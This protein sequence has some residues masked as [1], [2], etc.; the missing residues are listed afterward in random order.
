MIAIPLHLDN[1]GVW[2]NGWRFIGV[3][4]T[5]LPNLQNL[6]DSYKG[7]GYGGE[8][9]YPV[10]SHYANW[11]LTINFHNITRQSAELMMQESM[12]VEFLPAFEYQDP[13]SHRT[14]VE[15]WRFATIIQPKGVDLSTLEVGVKQ[16]M[17][18]LCGCTY[19]KASFK[20]ETVFEKDKVNIIDE[21]L[22]TDY[23]KPVRQA[24]GIL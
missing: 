6:T 10:R 16:N 7:S 15:G 14:F 4:T 8:Q 18:I 20:G 17:P 21:V 12:Q 11:E 23:A 9:D 22:H 5:V 1:Y 24:M 19:I 2:K 3:S 13:T